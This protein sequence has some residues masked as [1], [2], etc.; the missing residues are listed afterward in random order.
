MSM[1]TQG[2]V[3]RRVRRRLVMSV[4]TTMPAMMHSA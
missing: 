1:T 2:S 3:P 4:A